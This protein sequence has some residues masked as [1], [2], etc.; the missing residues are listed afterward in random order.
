[1]TNTITCQDTLTLPSFEPYLF[2]TSF[3][4][5]ESARCSK[6]LYMIFSRQKVWKPM[7]LIFTELDKHDR[8]EET[9]L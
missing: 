4:L 8:K 1:M 6:K 9:Q 2:P 7:Q 5:R 3:S